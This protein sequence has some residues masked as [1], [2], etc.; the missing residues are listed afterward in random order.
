MSKR[1]ASSSPDGPGK[2]RVT[3]DADATAVAPSPDSGAV[4]G[5][6]TSAACSV[7]SGG[8]AVGAGGAT[9]LARP[10]CTTHPRKEISKF[11]V[12]DRCYLC[13]V[14]LEGSVHERM[15]HEV[16]AA[17]H[18]GKHVLSALREVEERLVTRQNDSA[19]RLAEMQRRM[20]ELD[21]ERRRAL[22]REQELRRARMMVQA[23]R[24]ADED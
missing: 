6:E 4:D 13:E 1:K 20:D 8:S 19:A 17:E 11:C 10:M 14:C 9:E 7:R 12:L 18:A 2:R 15:G 16:I 21:Q 23:M 5:G 24:G 3:T 22:A